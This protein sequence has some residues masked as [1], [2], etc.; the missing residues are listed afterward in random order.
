MITRTARRGPHRGTVLL[1]GSVVG[2]LLIGTAGGAVGASLVTSAQI[3][4][5]TIRAVDIRNNTI[6]GAK[7]KTGT[8]T[9]SDIKNRTI[10]AKDVKKGALT[11]ALVKDGSLRGADLAAE[12]LTGEHIVDGSVTG[13]DL[14]ADALARWAV[15]DVGGTLVRS[16]QGA[17]AQKLNTGQYEVTFA[18]SVKECAFAATIGN[19][20]SG[21]PLA[22]L[23]SATPRVGK[24]N[25][26][27]VAT[28]NEAGASAD[29]PFHLVVHC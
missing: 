7:I 28:A 29:R 6:T 24:D 15:V 10:L 4:N 26:V 14:A 5:G 23:V 21:T 18:G 22:G 27:F 20:V 17:A 11:S 12:T 13:A 8:L 3:K 16:T 2:A 1:V 9:S 19:P 25:G